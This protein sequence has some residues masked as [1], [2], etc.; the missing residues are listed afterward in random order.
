MSKQAD[1]FPT[2]FAQ[3]RLWILDQLVPGNP[4][5]NIFSALPLQAQN[6]AALERSLNE[7]IRRH[8]ALRTTFTTIDGQPVQVIAPVLKL[9]IPVVDLRGIPAAQRGV[10]LRRLAQEEAR[11]PFDLARGP[12]LRA[13]LVRPDETESVL[14]LTIHHIVSDGWSLGVFF[15]E[16]NTFHQAF[17][18]GR[19]ASLP[20][21]NVQYVDFA[22]WQ[23]DTLKGELLDQQLAY[24]RRQ[25]EGVPILRLPLDRPR[26]LIK[27]YRGARLP[28]QFPAALV[29]RLRSFAQSE[30]ATTFM[31]LLAALQLL[32][33]RY[34]GQ[35]DVAVGSP[36]AGRNRAELEDLIGFF[37]NTLVLRTD[38]SGDPT[39]R[40]LL[41]RVRKVATDAYAHQDLP[42]EMLVEMVQ[43]ERDL[44]RNPLFQ[45][46]FQVQNTPSSFGAGPS[47]KAVP[48]SPAALDIYS[49]TAKF[50]LELSLTEDPQGL[51]GHFEFSTELFDESTIARMAVHF[52]T[53]LESIADNPDTPVS[54]LSFLT[55]DERELVVFG[56]NQTRR[57]YARDSCVHTIFES[58]VQRA[59]DAIAIVDAGKRWTYRALDE[60]A[61]ALASHL[62][63]MGAGPGSLVAVCMER[64]AEMI[65]ALLAVL[66]S[67]A[68]Y[69][70]VDPEYPR[71]RIAFMLSD[72]E[73]CVL[74]TQR[75][76]VER[77][78][79]HCAQVMCLDEVAEWTG[80]G[81]ERDRARALTASDLAYVMYTSGSTGTPKGVCIPHRAI[82]RLVLN[83]DY[84][85]LEP[86]DCLGH[87]SSPSFDAATFEVWGAL[88]LGG[89]IVVIPKNVALS[90]FEFREEIRRQGVTA[91]FLTSALF[92]QLASE[93]PRMFQ[94]MRHLLVGG[95]AV[96][97]KWAREV[98][99]NDPPG[100]L[101]NGYGPTES[102]TF[103]AC[104][105]IQ[106]VPEGATTIPIGRPI[107][108]TQL[109]ILDD[110]LEPVPV[111][112]PGEL[113]IGGDGLAN[114][115]LKRA[116][117]TAEKFVSHPFNADPDA[118]LYK[119]GDLVRWRATGDV[120]FLGR[121]D[122]Q[123]KVRGFRV[124]LGEIEADLGQHPAVQEAVVVARADAHGDTRL[125]AYVVPRCMPDAA[126]NETD[127]DQ[128]AHHQVDSWREIFDSHV[129]RQ[130]AES[131]DPKFNITGWNSSYTGEP[132]PETD[133]RE[134][135]DDT[136]ERILGLAPRRVLEIGCGTGLLLFRV[137]E[138]CS[139]YWGTD[140]S[141]TALEYIRQVMTEPGPLLPQVK[142]L[143]RAADD[144]TDIEADTF[145]V[146]IL[147]SVVQYFPNVDYLQRVV[148]GA[149][150]AVRPGGHVFIGDV[151]SLPLLQALHTSIELSKADDATT[152]E[153]LRERAQTGMAHET[154][155]VVDPKFFNS[156]PERI[157]KVGHVEVFPKRGSR[158]N[159]LTRFRYQAVLHIG[160]TP[161]DVCD[162]AWIDWREQRWDAGAVRRILEREQPAV[163]GL[164]WV[165]NA[166][167]S[168]ESNLLETVER[169]DSPATVGALREL[170]FGGETTAIDPQ[171]FWV[172]EEELPY[173]VVVSWTRHRREGQFDVA[174]VRRSETL[175]GLPTIRFPADATTRKDL[176]HFANNPLRRDV[177]RKLV[178]QLR[179]FLQERLPDFMVP[180]AF[181]VMGSLSLTPNGKVDRK[182]LPA[183][184]PTR[185]ELEENYVAPASKAEQILAG[186]WCEVL[187]VDRVGARDNFFELGGDSILSIQIISRAR[188]AGLQLTPQQVFQQQTIADLAA[189][190]ETLISAV[191]EQELLVGEVP[192]TPVQRWF[193]EQG[194]VE[195]H[196][197]NQ[198][199][200]LTV[201]P[202]TG[203][204][205]MREAVGHLLRHH[206]ALR[207]RLQPDGC[208]WTQ[209][210]G[211]QT[212]EIPFSESD[213][214]LLPSSN[215]MAAVEQESELIQA[216]LNLEEGPL[217][218]VVLF[219]LGPPH[220][221]R[222]L[223][224][225]HHLAIDGVSWRILL[226]DLQ[227]GYQQLSR[228]EPVKL[229]AKTTSFKTWAE[230]L[231]QYAGSAPVLQELSFWLQRPA[232][233]FELPLDHEH[234][235]NIVSAA[236][237]IEVALTP[238][239]TR[240]LLQDVPAAYR[241][242]VNDALLTAL[243]RTLAT[244]TGKTNLLFELEGHG[245]EDLF[246]GID[247]SR[248]IGW[249]TTIFPV[250]LSIKPTSRPAETLK[251]VKAQLR[252]IPNRGLGYGVLRYL[253]G[254][255][256]VRQRLSDLPQSQL[257]FNYF[258]Q[259]G[260]GARA[261][262]GD[263]ETTSE[264]IGSARGPSDQRHYLLEINGRVEHGALRVVWTYSENRHCR[265]TISRVA[266]DFVSELRKLLADCHA[267]EQTESTPSDFPGLEI[268]Q[269]ELD[270][271]LGKVGG[272]EVE[273]IYQ[274]SP[275]QEVMLFQTLYAP[276]AG[277]YLEQV[278]F[279]YGGSINRSAFRGA[280]EQ[281]AQLYTV[282]RS[283]F[284]WEDVQQPVQV[285]LNQ[286]KLPWSEY[287]LSSLPAYDR[288]KAI[289]AYLEEDR[290]RGFDLSQAPLMHF[291]WFQLTP[292]EHRFIWSFHH[293]ILDGW[294]LQ[295][296]LEKVGIAYGALCHNLDTML[297]PVRPFGDYIRW[298]Q[299][300]DTIQAAAFW[301]RQL[302]GITAP[303]RFNIDND[304]RTRNPSDDPIGVE[305]TLISAL[306]TLRLKGICRRHQLT[307][308]A[309]LLGVWALL[310][311]RYSNETDVLFG[312]V[313]S[314]RPAELPGIESMVGMFINSLP[315]RVHV[316]PDAG[317]IG[318]LK[319][320]QAQQVEMRKYEYSHLVQVQ[321][322][323]EI[324]G[325]LPMFESVVVFENFPIA[326][327]EK[328]Q[329]EQ[330]GLALREQNN[331][332]LSIMVVPTSEI[333]IRILYSS[334]RFD[335]AAVKRITGH[336][337]TA[338]EGMATNPYCTVGEVP[339]LTVPERKQLLDDWNNTYQEITQTESL[340]DLFE[341]QCARTPEAVALQYEE[342]RIT[343]AEL[344]S[345]SNRLARHLQTIGV[346]P[347][348]LVGVCMER[349]FDFVVGLLATFKAG[350]A[351]LPLDPSYPKERLEFMLKDAGV[352]VVLT[353]KR[354]APALRARR[355]KLFCVDSDAA[356]LR[357][358]PA[359]NL[360]TH[361]SPQQLAYVIYTSGSTG[362]PKGAL[363]LYSATLNRF[364]WMWHKYPFEAGEVCCQK[365][366]LGFVDSIWEIFGPL[367]QGV[368]VVI[369]PEDE[370]K[371][372]ERLI[373][374]LSIHCV[375]RL[376][377]VP[378]LLAVVLDTGTDLAKRLPALKYC[379]CSGERLSL[380][381]VNDFTEKL[382]HVQL[383]NLYG[384][385]EVAGDVTFYEV[386][387]GAHLNSVPIG[388]PIANT[389]IYIL[390]DNLQPVP[391]G[392]PGELFVG[393]LGLARGYLKRPELTA[394]K[395]VPDPFSKKPGARLYRTGDIARFLL[396]GNVDYI[397]RLDNQVKIRGYRMELGEIEAVLAEH[398]AVNQAIVIAHNGPA[399]DKRL[400]AYVVARAK[401]APNPAE[402]RR[403]L[404]SKLPEY[405]M[406]AIFIHLDAMPLT[407]NGKVNRQAFP[408]PDDVGPRADRAIVA[409]RNATEQ[410]LVGI[411][412]KVLGR[413][414]E[415]ISIDDHFFA[416]LGG[417]S[418]L[419]TQLVSRV[420]TALKVELPLRRFF[421][422]PTIEALAREIDRM[423][424]TKR[425]I[426]PEIQRIGREPFH[427]TLPE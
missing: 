214:R 322:V 407:P 287:D 40:E 190:A 47:I 357:R 195:A 201:D 101:L 264:S 140:F 23:R 167:L 313:V 249:F 111:G 328:N 425:A 358:Y 251:S 262:G 176:S 377:L 338:L 108:N 300:Q 267:V 243:S 215:Q 248:T 394:A 46:I 99:R 124:E 361:L 12:L 257:S 42:F 236:R 378:S 60:R 127:L 80:T 197:F 22:V 152:T 232:Q 362:K 26:P 117:L 250:W 199:A 366:S 171:D 68:A 9:T 132:L 316:D 312:T 203:T 163:L 227:T 142:L 218:R 360:T 413:N 241:T 426:T 392:V 368:P 294:S 137:A 295:T 228:S 133:M 288:E 211:E 273:D 120:E 57:E 191:P 30:N 349:S 147:N 341:A 239:E 169:D 219:R 184:D 363:G 401:L 5:Y 157:F 90:P 406:P 400:V 114:G 53:L 396:D 427:I 253:S 279:R 311:S 97:P 84:V 282:L 314:G 210:Y 229:P 259:F 11:R 95:S 223:I 326:K 87:I 154:E 261:S 73:A 281:V 405:M 16:L 29:C 115:Y 275:M 31:T 318:W 198:A 58:Q 156:M 325:G 4:F 359:K 305:D 375:T 119:T 231:L 337:C 7:I 412:S 24:W 269:D 178:P 33:C 293:L 20:K 180:S 252:R 333:L 192:L 270:Q 106:N 399:T 398:P 389:Q 340:V 285:V 35:D 345:R 330:Q 290:R 220:R 144:F 96:D 89:R 177:A 238:E 383:L 79:K 186:I 208:E 402:L 72:T 121:M 200:L 71:A 372:C 85:R 164:T 48:V 36:I 55:P 63:S 230:C 417:H 136:V 423:R 105:H 350:G 45:V 343:Y 126:T 291:A 380:D 166:R 308:N 34:S 222:L 3:Q 1:I 364:A 77:L 332:P 306:T 37:V 25:L 247:L 183:P 139:T 347:K 352:R 216:S 303:T 379:V 27:T 74:M 150:R 339:I 193:V 187:G 19:P 207:L 14:L 17:V 54:R 70:P 8:E 39:F 395:F 397:G 158:R 403:F 369:I 298:V 323:S 382:P 131:G 107:A 118:R 256:S 43:P 317:L 265:E 353:Q 246:P 336:L 28:V 49:G 414:P 307:L 245:R 83:T 266:E 81:E 255:P 174:F 234:G 98:L 125:V 15:R 65:A 141:P 155:L 355:R 179:A 258:G 418:L 315:I 272:D 112:V 10:E 335:A 204:N 297:E 130:F 289:Q 189:V 66:K 212:D 75:R 78:P 168:S 388:R 381:L 91:M 206:D 13:T 62:R 146:V 159:E 286:V 354:F 18:I 376:V 324:R 263:G 277:G 221:D 41:Q 194:L 123:V 170:S 278:S 421:E 310:L 153:Q 296:V 196:H 6:A 181:V 162:P 165:A 51:T 419:A 93:N 134:W 260:A 356:S 116:A 109:Y 135:L 59:P 172:L 237:D 411:W 309:F 404:K 420:R 319:E 370:A 334:G 233:P 374:L 148:E 225:V 386:S 88:L 254:D 50:D 122:E 244:W 103:A 38:V 92:N 102:T 202:A 271:L 410:L 409:S 56:W 367:L 320:I 348:T 2:S 373:E 331:L 209:Y 242:Q 149:V 21:L 61:N 76:F 240:A 365:T 145:D 32:L 129:Y 304:T 143:Q 213:L 67:G 393:G 188:Q 69:V 301:R 384:S 100:R 342:A 44:S 329:K 299:R 385:S 387:E 274:L 64:S 113:Y 280:W 160:P 302:R 52:E 182:M 110:H 235:E 128:I 205:C 104:Y 217:V 185:P 284:F 371:D 416:D 94:T 173:D 424:I 86:S 351:Y 283:C 82:S 346:G 268:S 391:I 408:Q 321:E 415:Q 327:P 161:T 422:S 292:N 138:N 226:E 276:N 175:A 390:D 224:V 344:N 151:R